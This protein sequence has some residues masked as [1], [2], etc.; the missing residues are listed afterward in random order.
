MKTI[1]HKGILIDLEFLSNDKSQV[2]VLA[3]V[4]EGYKT[5]ILDYEMD[6][7]ERD[8]MNSEELALNNGMDVSEIEAWALKTTYAGLCKRVAEYCI[9]KNY[10][11]DVYPY[12]ETIYC[13]LNNSAGVSVGYAEGEE[14]I[15][16]LIGQ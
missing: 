11:F 16:E 14:N 5:F 3:T 2:E 13:N 4:Q 7:Y 6:E 1:E 12:G 10:T 15:L 9:D 8:A